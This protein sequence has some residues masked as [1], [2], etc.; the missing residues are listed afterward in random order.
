MTEL[1]V[2]RIVETSTNR[3]VR[4]SEPTSKHNAEKFA[5]GAGRNLN[6][7]KYH[8]AVVPAPERPS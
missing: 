4:E 1:Y 8:V 7:E 2:G 6:W 3:V 5:D